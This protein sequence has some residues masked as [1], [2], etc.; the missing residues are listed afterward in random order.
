M[1]SP[2]EKSWDNSTLEFDTSKYKFKEWAISSIQELEPSISKLETLHLHV[3]PE[4]LSQIKSHFYKSTL[5]YDFM[6]LIDN[7]MEDYIPEIIENKKY[8]IQRYPTLR[9]VEPNQR[10]NN[11]KRL[12]FHQDTWVGS[13]TGLRTIWM[14]FTKCYSSNSMLI[15]PLDISRKISKE[16]DETWSLDEFEKECLK[17]SS[18]VT[19][20]YGQC[21]LFLQEHI[22]GN[23]NNET[24]TTR[25]SMD[26]RVL[27]KSEP[28]HR[29]YPG[30]YLRF[31]GDYRSDSKNNYS[32]KKFITYDSWNSKYTKNIPLPLQRSLIDQYCKQKKILPLD[33]RLESLG[34][35]WCPNLQSYIK[36]KP[37]GI[38]LL[39]IFSLPDS[40]EWRNI[41]LE[42][43]LHNKVEL[44][45]A[46]EY[47]TLKDRNDL[48]L[49]K[50]YLEFSLP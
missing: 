28:Y 38:V 22:H 19:L 4:R 36:E 39:S 17:Y 14:P 2:T 46:N 34:H 40:V 23:I 11:F 5:K 25:V 21:H 44:H 41:I 49:I 35:D 26:I 30:G 1:L 10:K 18:P 45:F 42:L 12:A 7:F 13:G 20:N 15:L 24:E 47:I 31:P 37:D 29:R 6:K 32:T 50:K 33:D 43:A 3:E 48:E 16:Y 9:I 27:I 8:L